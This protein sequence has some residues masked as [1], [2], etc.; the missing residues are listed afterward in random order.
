MHARLIAVAGLV[1]ASAALAQGRAAP[2]PE[3]PWARGVSA[4][5]Q[6]RALE[7][8]RE[9]NAALKESLFVK[10]AQVYRDA[11]ALWDHPA[12]HYNLALALVNLDQPVETFE[13][14][15]AA[16]KYGAAPLDADK[17][18]QAQRYK[19]LIEKQLSRVDVRCDLD[20]AEVKFDGKPVFTAPGRWQGVVRSGP[21]SVSATRDGYL[22]FEQ[23]V[24]LLG[25]ELKVFDVTLMRAED[26][27]E[28]RRL[29]PAW[30]P[31]AVVAGGA[32]VTG[33]SV[34]LH[35]AARSGYQ[36]YDQGIQGC[37]DPVTGGCTPSLELSQKKSSADSL[38]AVAIVGYAVG[39]AALVTGAV[40]VYLNR[41][42][43]FQK[44]VNVG[45]QVTLVPSLGPAG[46][47]ATLFV[48]F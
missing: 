47:G 44:S 15:E 33:T 35:L 34:G 48:Q 23:S 20:G 10:A 41:L 27:T 2:E 5:K 18:E 31:W 6:K 12:I 24:R 38:Q 7:L 39:G 1:L 37:L 8:F 14:L 3:R 19:T 16:L 4:D 45:P 21:H 25:A 17:F 11:L 13:H 29:W 32:I 28:Y 43:P 22:P 40:L 26:L 30:I 46:A 42:Q 36:S 9:G